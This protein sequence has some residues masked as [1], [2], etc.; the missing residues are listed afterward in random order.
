MQPPHSQ[1]RWT[2]IIKKMQHTFGCPIPDESMATLAIYLTNQN[3]IKPTALNPTKVQEASSSFVPEKVNPNKGKVIYTTNCIN[4]H[5]TKGLGDGPIGQ[6]LIPPAADLTVIGKK[7]DQELLTTIQ[8]GR[9]GTAM[10][11][12]KGNLSAQDIT[13]VLSYVRSLSRERIEN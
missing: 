3:E 4:C 8:N 5:G 1:G 11:S 9:P 2:E 7:S 12:W 6:M 10:P 13:D